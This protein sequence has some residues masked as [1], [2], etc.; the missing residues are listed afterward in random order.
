VREAAALTIR[1]PCH[2]SSRAGQA[3]LCHRTEADAQGAAPM[4]AFILATFVL[5]GASAV[6]ST[7]LTLITAI[8]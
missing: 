1:A 3:S 8:A 2:S 7:I 5:V 4:H 6:V